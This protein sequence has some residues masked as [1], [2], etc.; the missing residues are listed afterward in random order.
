MRSVRLFGVA[1]VLLAAACGGGVSLD[2]AAVT[3]AAD[4][5][6]NFTVPVPEGTE[7]EEP[8]EPDADPVVQI[9]GPSIGPGDSQIFS[10]DGLGHCV[11]IVASDEFPFEARVVGVAVG[12]GDAFVHDDSL[13][14]SP[15]AHC[16]GYVFPAGTLGVCRVGAIWHPD[17]G[18]FVGAVTLSFRA[19]CWDRKGPFCEKL[20]ADP[21][22]GGTAVTWQSS[23]ALNAEESPDTQDPP[24]PDEDASPEENASPDE[25]TEST[26]SPD[27]NASPSAQQTG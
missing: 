18:V 12:P 3:P 26:P 6:E 25:G 13:C 8:Q 15:P 1:F 23:L 17:S 27:P 5:E 22:A 9:A 4:T 24:S 10:I 7:T 11:R 19:T 20:K 16:E 2:D 14:S 21:P